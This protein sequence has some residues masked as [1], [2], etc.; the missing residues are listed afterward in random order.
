[1]KIII[2]NG[3][4]RNTP[5]KRSPDGRFREYIYTRLIAAAM[6]L[7]LHYRGY[8]YEILVPE[9]E[10]ISLKERVR[11]VNERCR[12]LGKEN[13]CLVSIHVN[14]AGMGD[15]WYDATGWSCY[16]SRGQTAGDM[17]ADCLYFAAE[18]HLRG[19]RIRKDYSDGDPDLESDFYLL[20][21]TACAAVLTENGYQDCVRSLEYLESE[22]G[23]RAIVALHVEG[24]INYV[25]SLNT[26]K[27]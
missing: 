2:D 18:Q 17:L 7:H 26:P 3:H 11:R 13:V 1:M 16:T 15:R 6:A 23:R 8:D 27:V 4:G 21:H 19:H 9:E 22:E 10:D 5:G 25:Q 20:K 14:A 12:Q 24:I